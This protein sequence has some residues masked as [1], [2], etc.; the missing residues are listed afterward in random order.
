MIGDRSNS[1]VDFEDRARTLSRTMH[2]LNPSEAR[3]SFYQILESSA[4]NSTRTC[5]AS[6][7]GDVVIMSRDEVE[8]LEETA[9][10]LAQPGAADYFRRA[11]K[12]PLSKGTV[13]VPGGR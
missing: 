13:W 4:R 1:S 3:R 5:V 2:T 10:I 7:S 12:E 9:A 11:L 8:G 6:K